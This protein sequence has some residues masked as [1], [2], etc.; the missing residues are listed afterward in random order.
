MKI[1]AP[2]AEVWELVEAACAHIADESQYRRLDELILRDE[3]VARFYAAYMDQHASLA[4]SRRAKGQASGFRVQVETTLM[5]KRSRSVWYAVAAMIVLAVTAWFIFLPEPRTQNPEP[6]TKRSIA[7]LTNAQDAVFAEGDIGMGL[8]RELT[9]GT[10]K[11]LSGQAQL[12]FSGGAVVDLTGPCALELVSGGRGRLMQG[13]LAAYVPA[14]AAGFRIDTPSGVSVVDLGTEFAIETLPPGLTTVQVYQGRVRLQRD[15]AADRILGEMARGQIARI[16]ASG[17]IDF[18]RLPTQLAALNFAGEGRDAGI[19]RYPGAAG[20]GWS[21]SWNHIGATGA[22][23][24]RTDQPLG[25]GEAYLAFTGID[26]KGGGLTRR[27]HDMGLV[28]PLRWPYAVGFDVR[29]DS[30]QVRDFQLGVR[31]NNSVNTSADVLAYAKT[32]D[33]TWTVFDGDGAGNTTTINTH[34]PA[35]A[36]AVYHIEF[37]ID[38]ASMTYTVT[39]DNLDDNAPAY[40]SPTLNTRNPNAVAEPYLFVGRQFGGAAEAFSIDSITIRAPGNPTH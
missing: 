21:G 31:A 17:R 22:A 16:D 14:T 15:D 24:V 1:A 25:G 38:P 40:V 13:R 18:D 5:P 30:D 19:D 4:W 6:S 7:L 10:V 33:A 39:I 26:P 20:E 3:Q 27:F 36:G 35:V 28:H 29:I 37:H 8:G 12:M 9:G 23:A 2:S 11:L 32:T 34:L